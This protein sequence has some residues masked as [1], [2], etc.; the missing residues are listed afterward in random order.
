MWPGA[1]ERVREREPH[2]E[3]RSRTSQKVRTTRGSG[4]TGLC[5]RSHLSLARP[6]YSVG[7]LVAGRGHRALLTNLRCARHARRPHD[8]GRPSQFSRFQLASTPHQLLHKLP[9][10]RDAITTTRKY[11]PLAAV[12]GIVVAQFPA[13][14]KNRVGSQHQS[15]AWAI[16]ASRCSLGNAAPLGHVASR[17]RRSYGSAPHKSASLTMKAPFAS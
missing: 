5:C 1:P 3:P 10:Q 14:A 8:V 9:D 4:P 11:R 12:A 2:S 15:P 6:L 7:V 16:I 17:Y 13:T